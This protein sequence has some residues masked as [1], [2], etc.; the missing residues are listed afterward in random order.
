MAS[1]IAHNG[2]LAVIRPSGE[3]RR[4]RHPRT[5]FR[6]NDAPR[7]PRKGWFPSASPLAETYSKVEFDSDLKEAGIGGAHNPAKRRAAEVP[8]DGRGPIKLRMVDYIKR[9]YPELK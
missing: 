1:D 9:L 6:D 2:G 5:P 4:S 7:V 3:G 8:A